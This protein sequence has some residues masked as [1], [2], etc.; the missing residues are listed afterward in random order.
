M[1]MKRGFEHETT[2][3]NEEMRRVVWVMKIWRRAFDGSGVNS[4]LVGTGPAPAG[5][6]MQKTVPHSVS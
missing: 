5:I 3:D 2:D 4:V 6:T 1:M